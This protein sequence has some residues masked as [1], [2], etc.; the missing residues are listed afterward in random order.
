MHTPKRRKLNYPNI[1]NHVSSKQSQATLPPAESCD[2]SCITWRADRKFLAYVVHALTPSDLLSQAGA[3]TV[4][5]NNF[6][7]NKFNEVQIIP[8]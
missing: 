7:D 4:C 2:I 6:Q 5:A 1:Q 8:I 3:H